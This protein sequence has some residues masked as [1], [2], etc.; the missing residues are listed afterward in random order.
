MPLFDREQEGGLTIVDTAGGLLVAR[1]VEHGT[2]NAEGRRQR[3][4]SAAIATTRYD[5]VIVETHGPRPAEE[6]PGTFK[7]GGCTIVEFTE[8]SFMALDPPTRAGAGAS[9][10][11]QSDMEETMFVSALGDFIPFT[12]EQG[13]DLFHPDN[14]A[15]AAEALST[16]F[17]GHYFSLA[18]RMAA[19]GQLGVGIKIN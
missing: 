18:M 1:L 16:D 8:T 7:P 5:R 17:A 13:I 15:A 10:P 3:M 9:I 4:L 6:I 2:P 12:E 19:A 11:P 14:A